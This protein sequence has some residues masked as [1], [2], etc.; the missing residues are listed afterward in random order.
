MDCIGIE[1]QLE[2]FNGSPVVVYTCEP[3]G[4]F[5]TTFIS[6]G[7]SALLGWEASD[8]L[9]DPSFWGSH[10]HP[11]DKGRVL[12]GISSLFENDHY[13]L[14]YRFR[15]KDGSYRWMSDMLQLE[16]NE[17]GEPVRIVGYWMDI[18][19]QKQA[20]QALSDSEIRYRQ[21]AELSPD[22]IFVHV[23]D[24]IVFAN[25]KLA[26]ILETSS[27]ADL[28]GTPAIELIAPEYR[29]RI[30]RRR[31]E[32]M[33]GE[34]TKL[35]QSEFLRS[36]GSRVAVEHSGGLISWEGSPA[37]LVLVRDVSERE[38]AA[39]ALRE[40]D[41]RFRGVIE[42]SPT[43]LSLKDPE[44]RFRLV[45]SRFTEWFGKRPEELIGKTVPDIWPKD[46]SDTVLALD[47]KVMETGRTH[48]LDHDVLF[49]DGTLHSVVVTKFPVLGSDNKTIGIGTINSDVTE[50][51]AA[52]RAVAE[53]R[54]Q[55]RLVT[56]NLPA[57][58]AYS[59]AQQR[60]RFANKTCA[61]WF[62]RPVE[63]IVGRT[64]SELF[65]QE[66]EKVRSRVGRALAG[67]QLT[68]VESITHPDNV[69]RTVQVTYVPHFGA[70]GSVE[71]YF[72]LVE[73][74]SELQQAE[75]ALRQAQK[76][77]AV[78]QLTGGVAHDFNNL[79]AVIMGNAELLHK[80]IGDY[81]QLA[82]I[83]RASK[84]AA[85]LTQRLLS[86]SR[87][88]ML[89][90]QSIDLTEL[91]PGLHDLLRRTLG[92]P[93]KIVTDVTEET[94]PILADPGQ[95]ENALLNLAINARDAMPEGGILEITCSNI[96]LQEGDR[97]VS[98][99]IAA[100]DY[101]QITVRDTG[102][103][104]PKDVLEHVFEPFYTTKDVGEGSGLGLSMVY[105]F[106]RQSGGDAV[107]ESVPGK[108]TEIRLFLPRAEAKVVSDEP[109]QE[110]ELKRGQDQ[111]I[112]VLEDDPD[113]RSF[114]V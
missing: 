94:W 3:D 84:R 70:A 85:E 17:S 44:G 78:G 109:K 26:Q 52:E 22:G 62:A 72:T 106:A 32:V 75:E 48:E 54:D 59:D 4:D 42:N 61:E 49:A 60:Y 79:L 81:K 103:G 33:N 46:H 92:E 31:C 89:Q 83:E 57:L 53:S 63:E 97:R 29:E 86:F 11:D 12:S 21:M 36:D 40:S 15:H 108:G 51:V 37:I 77:E 110:A 74:I 105:G 28:F 50:R 100:G 114:A 39:R 1:G 35:E 102:T 10:I 18:S 45:N 112:L 19:A 99:E 66:N 93:V 67:E 73:D 30:I 20:K 27:P 25:A 14:E 7:V 47:R 88:Q 101:V 8:F 90:S 58:I 91:V 43:S 87:K 41:E 2:L 80:K 24:E 23:D 6:P 13:S 9:T 82:A 64:I 111:S 56:D 68:Y 38:A 98:D 34:I 95:L 71:G 65:G 104:I 5:A 96:E 69:T 55:L 76:M 113:V 107:I 16:R